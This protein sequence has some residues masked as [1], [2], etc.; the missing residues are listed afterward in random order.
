[1][2]VTSRPGWDKMFGTFLRIN[3]DISKLSV[4]VYIE[5]TINAW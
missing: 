3:F 1:M 2:W 5:A 4:L